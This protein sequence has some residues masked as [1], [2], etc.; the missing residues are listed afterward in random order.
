MNYRGVSDLDAATRSLAET[1]PNDIDLVVG[2]P[3]SGLLAANLL[4][5]YLDT[6][7]TDV[8]GLCAGTVYESG[9]RLSQPASLKTAE[10]VFVVDDSVH[11]GEQMRRTKNRIDSHS[12][13]FSIEYGAIYITPSGHTVVDHWAEVISPPRVF[14]WNVLHHPM[15]RNY[16]VDIDGVLCRDPT[17]EENDDGPRYREFIKSVSPH[18]IPDERIGWLVTCRLEKYR[19]LTEDWL[20]RHGIA[21]DHLVMMDY[22]DKETR[23]AAGNHASYKADIYESTEASL[24][25]ESDER[26]AEDIARQTGRSVFCYEAYDMIHPGQIKRLYRRNTN[27][28]T[29]FL[30]NPLSFSRMAGEYLLNRGYHRLR[31]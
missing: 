21:Y 14:G 23:K 18:I 31:R 8:D 29:S 28:V 13:P 17:P 24:F 16:C 26:Q 9:E 20:D 1:L 19:S 27:H 5:L 3:R 12:L 11:S 4:C 10:T 7:M 30:S 15:V 2:I 22:P 25:V 6:P